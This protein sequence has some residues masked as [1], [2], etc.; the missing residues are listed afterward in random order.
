MIFHQNHR[1]LVISQQSQYIQ[2]FHTKFIIFDVFTSIYDIW[3]FTD[4]SN[5]PK[6]VSKAVQQSIK[7]SFS[8]T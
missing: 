5:S 4:T 7:K 3:I 2:Y 8:D 6:I 1:F